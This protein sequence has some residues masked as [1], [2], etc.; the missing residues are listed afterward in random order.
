MRTG[1]GVHRVRRA[2]NST[3]S[4]AVVAA[5]SGPCDRKSTGGEKVATESW[6]SNDKDCVFVTDCDVVIPPRSRTQKSAL[7]GHVTWNSLN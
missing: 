3:Q 4:A 7:Q 2:S 6:P 5:L 1:E